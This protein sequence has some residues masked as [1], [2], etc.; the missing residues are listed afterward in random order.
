MGPGGKICYCGPPSEM[1][2]Y[3]GKQDLVEIY[4][5]LAVNTDN[6]NG[7]YLHKSEDHVQESEKGRWLSD[8]LCGQ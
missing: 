4:N 2:E 5:E 8:Q 1:N 6:W 3:F 7:Y